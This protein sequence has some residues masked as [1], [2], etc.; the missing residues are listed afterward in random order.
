MKISS[1]FSSLAM[2]M[3]VAVASQSASADFISSVVVDDGTGLVVLTNGVTDGGA[4]YSAPQAVLQSL[5]AGGIVYDTLI[6]PDGYVGDVEGV[7]APVGTVSFPSASVALSDLDLT[8][9]SL[10]PLGTGGPP[11]E[12]YHDFRTQTIT[13]DTVFFLFNNGTNTQSVTLV[14]STG[15]AISNSLDHNTDLSSTGGE[16]E[17]SDFTFSRTNGGDLANRE[18]A[19]TIFAVSEFTFNAGFG[20]GDVAGF[21]GGGGTFDAQDAGIAI[22]I[23]E[24]ASFALLALGSICMLT[25][26]K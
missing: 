11:T 22:A 26:R 10:D 5:T 18:V 25:R 23:P 7:L 17:L 9:G 4:D 12:E 3:A 21:R 16:V 6:A 13:N 8:T 24:P 14:D 20:V 1:T 19:G 15:G 2:L